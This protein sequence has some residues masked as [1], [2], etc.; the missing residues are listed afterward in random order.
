M[1]L[2]RSG[3]KIMLQGDA[4]YQR[5]FALITKVLQKH[6]F[7]LKLSVILTLTTW[8]TTIQSQ[9]IL[10]AQGYE[11]RPKS[12]LAISI[13]GI[14][15]QGFLQYRHF[16]QKSLPVPTAKPEI[17][18]GPDYW[19]S[20]QYRPKQAK[21]SDLLMASQLAIPLIVG[22]SRSKYPELYSAAMVGAQ[23]L[24]WTMNITQGIKLLKL[25]S[26]P[27]VYSLTTPESVRNNLDAR[28]SFLSGHSSA[29]FCIA[30]STTL[31]LKNL[32]IS[33]TARTIIGATSFIT[34]GSIATLRIASG[35]HYPTDVLAGM[36]L[37]CGVALLNH[38]V[39]VRN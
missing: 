17:K 3:M 12:D 34:A 1:N 33:G 8:N 15:L 5:G 26:R 16:Q 27:L 35:K 22:I 28:Y 39:H 21:C 32:E 2:C 30:T 29:A 38:Y 6:F 18:R 14:A 11:F 37:G 31:A 25:R 19:F 4:Q 23:S 24:L 9:G 36:L 20:Y 10:L 13:S 7:S